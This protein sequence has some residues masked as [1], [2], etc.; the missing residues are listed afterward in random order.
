MMFMARN[1]REHRRREEAAVESKGPI[2]VGALQPRA[3]LGGTRLIGEH[4]D[5]AVQ[6]AVDPR[7]AVK[8]VAERKIVYLRNVGQGS[9]G[10]EGE[11]CQRR[12]N[13]DPHCA[14]KPIE[15]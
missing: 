12:L 1:C 11:A 4:S 6:P 8:L 2:V 5:E 13:P 9:S 10:L 7:D 15:S 14:A 3:G